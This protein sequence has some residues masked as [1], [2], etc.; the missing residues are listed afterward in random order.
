MTETLPQVKLPARFAVRLD[1]YWQSVAIYA[2]VLILYV[3]IKAMWESTLQSGI[4]NVVVT[5]PMVVLLGLFVVVSIIALIVNLVSRRTIIV[6]DDG[7]TFVSRY[8]QRTF[9]IDEIDRI[10]LGRERR[11]KIRGV[12][13]LVKVH[14]RGR[15]RSIRIRPAVYEN[16]QDLVA[17]LFTLRERLRPSPSHGRSR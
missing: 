9:S 6:A 2:V 5:D 3:V 8:H 16:E 13:S 15:R 10:R 14:I 1:S 17:A 4:V 11:L 7:I 12:L